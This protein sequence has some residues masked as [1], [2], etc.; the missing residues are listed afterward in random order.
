MCHPVF[1]LF[2][3]FFLLLLPFSLRVVVAL[4]ADLVYSNQG[5]DAIK[6]DHPDLYK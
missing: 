5:A 1:F 4:V 2:A 6:A 3:A